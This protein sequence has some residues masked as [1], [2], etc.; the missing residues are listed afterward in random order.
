[1]FW[2]FLTA[3]LIFL[4][5]N[6]HSKTGIYNYR[7]QIYADKAG[8]YIYLPATFIYQFDA[9]AFPEDVDVKTGNGFQLNSTNNKVITKYFYGVSLMELPFFLVAH[10]LSSPLG[11]ES[12][13]FS[14]I[15][16]WAIDLAAVFYLLLAFF[17]LYKIL[18]RQFP[19]KTA[20]L[21]I[22]FLFAGTNLFYYSIQDTGMSHVYSFFLFTVWIYQLT[23]WKSL[24]KRPALF[25]MT[26]GLIAALIVFVRPLNVLFLL[27]SIFFKRDY[28]HRLKAQMQG[29][30]L[31]PFLL[32]LFLIAAPQLSYW[33]YLG[34]SFFINPYPGES[35]V[36]WA[37]PEIIEFLFAPNNGLFLYTPLVLCL[38]TGLV[39][40]V[41][42]K[43][44]NG[45]L[46][47]ITVML[48]IYASSSWWSWHFG[49]GY[50]ARNFVEYYVLL[51]FPL[52]YLIRYP[53]P[54]KVK[55]LFYFLLIIFTAYN[56]KM[57]YSYGGCWFGKG[58]WDWAQYAHWLLKWP[59]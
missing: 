42:H 5:F 18:R 8:Y 57:I 14:L 29:R 34:G 50:S 3:L 19:E 4:A 47:S 41:L 37:N 32:M 39:F 49:C 17:L 24:I 36:N 15:Y 25:G 46:I 33:K 28:A 59:G 35:F 20:F 31:I 38:I 7:S 12:N 9:R 22:T 58:N 10:W 13:G 27:T 43:K 21:S 44:E 30:F 48:L 40:M 56:L 23:F 45:W 53:K 2:V 6:R 11:F 52:A 55:F 1:V 26:S 51:S 54:K 16:H